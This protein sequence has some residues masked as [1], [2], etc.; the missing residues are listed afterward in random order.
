MKQLSK[1]LLIVLFAVLVFA[2]VACTEPVE[3]PHVHE[4]TDFIITKEATCTENGEKTLKCEC[5]ETGEVVVIPA[6]GHKLV[7]HAKVGATCTEAGQEAYYECSTC[8]KLFDSANKEVVKEDLVIQALGH[9]EGAAVQE[10][11]VAAT[12]YSTGSYDMVTRCV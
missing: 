4:Y 7:Y 12:C 2:M 8:K 3:E 9:V 6:L 5:G 10:N 1:V 11:Y